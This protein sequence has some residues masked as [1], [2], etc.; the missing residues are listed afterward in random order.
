MGGPSSLYG[1]REDT[2]DSLLLSLLP[3]VGFSEF[4][5]TESKPVE[6]PSEKDPKLFLLEYLLQALRKRAGFRIPHVSHIRFALSLILAVF[7]CALTLYML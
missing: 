3:P 1:L 5:E 6:I 2:L 7:V 4:I